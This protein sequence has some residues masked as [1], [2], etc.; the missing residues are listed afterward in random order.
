MKLQALEDVVHFYCR[1]GFMHG[2]DCMGRKIVL[3][4]PDQ[5]RIRVM[6][7]GQVAHANGEIL[8]GPLVCY[9]PMTPGSVR[10]EKHEQISGAVTP[11][12]AFILP[13]L[14]WLGRGRLAHLAD[15]LRR[16]FI[17]AKH[18]TLRVDL[19]GVEIQYIFHSRN[20][21]TR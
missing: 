5:V 2:P 9:F 21:V 13:P 14:I 7:I 6:D 1:E 3:H 15:Q 12:L 20:V 8:R 4:G 18:R 11:A 10:I 16:T 19:F 17:E